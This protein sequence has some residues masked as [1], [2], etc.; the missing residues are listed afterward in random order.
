MT[1]AKRW[2]QRAEEYRMEALAQSMRICELVEE[3]KAAVLDGDGVKAMALLGDMAL[4]ARDIQDLM[5][6]AKRG[7]E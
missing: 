3:A 1:D 5:K 4:V 2:P 7:R 6:E